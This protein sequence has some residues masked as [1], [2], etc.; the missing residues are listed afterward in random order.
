MLNLVLFGPPGSG[1]GTQAALLAQKYGLIHISTGDLFRHEIK[2]QTPLGLRAKSFL[3]SGQL[4]PDEVTVGMFEAKLDAELARGAKGFIFDGFPRTTKQAE[5]L[6]DLLRSRRMSVSRVLSLVVA[7]EEL[8]R[9]MLKRAA[10]EGRS[11]DMD[12]KVIS[13]RIVEYNNKTTPVAGYYDMY[14]LLS[15]VPGEGT[16]EEIFERLCSAIEHTPEA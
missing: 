14:D 11:D 10:D 4:V 1:K 3:D 6:D 15:I 2:G 13:K 12:P 16:V 9:R 8:T 7:E 5:A